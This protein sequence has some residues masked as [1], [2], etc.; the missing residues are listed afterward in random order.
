MCRWLIWCHAR[1]DYRH[2]WCYLGGT[3]LLIWFFIQWTCGCRGFAR[4]WILSKRLVKDRVAWRGLWKDITLWVRRGRSPWK[5]WALRR[6]ALA[7]G[8]TGSDVTCVI[9]H[10]TW[11]RI[12]YNAT[13]GWIPRSMASVATWQSSCSGRCTIFIRP[14]RNAAAL[15]RSQTAMNLNKIEKHL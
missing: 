12:S 2:L 7:T 14:E 4:R 11:R 6:W 5:S 3:G 13:C 9:G 8:W 1:T 10:N 15:R